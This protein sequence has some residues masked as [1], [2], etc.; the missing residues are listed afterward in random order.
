MRFTL[1][2][3][4]PNKF[5]L[6]ACHELCFFDDS[7]LNGCTNLSWMQPSSLALISVIAFTISS[8]NWY[9]NCLLSSYGIVIVPSESLSHLINFRLFLM[10]SKSALVD[11]LLSVFPEIKLQIHIVFQIQL[12]KEIGI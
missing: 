7:N 10:L 12:T 5:K 2:F 3:V 11:S 8:R 1:S 4:L 6:N 9:L